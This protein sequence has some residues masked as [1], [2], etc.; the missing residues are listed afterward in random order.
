MKPGKAIT[1]YNEGGTPSPAVVDAVVG[2]GDSLYK[3]LDVTCD[4]GKTVIEDVVHQND[5]VAG[6][7][8]WTLPDEALN[9]PEV[10]DAVLTKART[11]RTKAASPVDDEA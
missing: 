11:F 2:T 7:G 6:K 10:V 1:Y 4:G 9:V 3:I 8:F 5:K